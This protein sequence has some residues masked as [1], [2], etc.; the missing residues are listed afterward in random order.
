[1]ITRQP[2]ENDKLWLQILERAR[3]AVGENVAM[4]SIDDLFNHLKDIVNHERS[5][6]PEVLSMFLPVDEALF[7]IDANTRKIKIPDMFVNGIAVQGDEMAEILYFS[8]DRYFD[9]VDLYDREI[10]IQWKTSKGDQ[11][12]YPAFNKSLNVKEGK[13]V[14]GWPITSEITEVSGPV[15]F[16]VRFYQNGT[17]KEG[18]DI[19]EYSFGT[20]TSTV[21]VNQSLNFD[22]SDPNN[23]GAVLVDKTQMLFDRIEDSISPVA[24]PIFFLPEDKTEV[25]IGDTIKAQAKFGT[26]THEK[27]DIEY[28]W[29]FVSNESNAAAVEKIGTYEY[30][31][32]VDTN[33]TGK[34]YY[35]KLEDN[36]YSL[37]AGDFKDGLYERQAV[38]TVDAIGSYQARA[39]NKTASGASADSLSKIFEVK[40]PE[41]PVIETLPVFLVMESG[42][43]LVV[44]A[45]SPDSGILSYQ[46]YYAPLNSSNK[47]EIAGATTN[48]IAYETF[49]ATG[50]G[51]YSVVVFNSKNGESKNKESS[52]CRLT[53][54]ASNFTVSL[55]VGEQVLTAGDL[56]SVGDTI[57][58]EATSTTSPFYGTYSYEWYEVPTDNIPVKIE[59]ATSNQ[60]TPNEAGRYKAVIVNTHY[61]SVVRNESVLVVFL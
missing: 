10:Y 16:S 45:S 3:E 33:R 41:L 42:K 56:R 61:D 49:T 24:L 18:N 54:P 47:N 25:Q 1:M 34:V 17:D 15:Q 30:I 7:E 2:L 20:L 22:I 13:V 37:Y 51:H 44:T 9:A 23:L 5:T 32:T 55:K 58:A 26:T 50:E 60:F 57:T 46:W 28:K 59:N 39:I 6:Y 43:N 38:L 21:K 11:A 14:F 4:N 35:E 48:S 27:G 8:I 36:T 19:L 53:Y 29:I 31:E 40:L 52:A 12:L